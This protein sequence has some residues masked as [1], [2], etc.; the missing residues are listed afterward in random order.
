LFE[1][2]IGEL[3]RRDYLWWMGESF[4]GNEERMMRQTRM[5]LRN[6]ES[7]ELFCGDL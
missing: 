2:E 5:F 4:Y 6:D 1:T 3:V 7:G